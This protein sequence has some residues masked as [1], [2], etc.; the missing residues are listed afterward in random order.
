MKRLILVRHSKTEHY[1]FEVTDFE[2]SLTKRG[3]SDAGIIAEQ[4]KSKGVVPDYF[5]SSKAKRA[6]QTTSVFAETME[7]PEKKVN[8]QQFLYNGYTTNEFL[9]FISTID[10]TYNTIIVIAHNPGI[11]TL[12]SNL[13]DE[14]FYH[15]PTTAT[16]V[17]D[18]DTDKWDRINPREGKVHLFLYPRIFKE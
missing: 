18:F 10:N 2:R 9:N 15:F 3:K 16:A 8:V 6:L 17:I 1:N 7:F 5:I 13:S 12:A 14:E 11:A 4:L